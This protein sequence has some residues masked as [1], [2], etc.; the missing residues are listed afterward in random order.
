[1][2]QAEDEPQ[3]RPGDVKI[4]F[5]PDTAVTNNLDAREDLK[6][7]EKREV[8]K[9]FQDLLRVSRVPPKHIFNQRKIGN[10]TLR[11]VRYEKAVEYMQ[12]KSKMNLSSADKCK[13][14]LRTGQIHNV[15]ASTTS[16]SGGR[17]Y[18]TDLQGELVK[19]ATLHLPYSAKASDIFGSVCGDQACR[20]HH[21]TEIF[22]RQQ[23][24]D[25][26]KNLSKTKQ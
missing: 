26:F 24:R 21:I 10:A 18:W 14:W 25:K 3:E 2:Q 4:I 7:E 15:A 9:V 20:D 17:R 6:I 11:T 19:K 1:M 16:S 5:V 23:I 22:T 8:V 13:S 12:Q